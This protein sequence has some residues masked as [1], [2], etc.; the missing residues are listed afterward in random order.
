MITLSDEEVALIRSLLVALSAVKVA[1]IHKALIL[2]SKV[3]HNL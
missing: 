2:L 3:D 1:D